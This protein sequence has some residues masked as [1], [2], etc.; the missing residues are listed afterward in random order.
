MKQD[1]P[2]S[3]YQPKMPGAT[4]LV[5]DLAIAVV[6][7]AWIPD[8]VY[9]P[10]IPMTE[11]SAW[12]DVLVPAWELK[13]DHNFSAWRH[14]RQNEG[15]HWDRSSSVP[16]VIRWVVRLEEVMPWRLGSPRQMG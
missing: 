15:Y 4:H 7:M 1:T 12:K 14:R 9:S 8:Q 16:V 3:P 13:T 5:N 6:V 10:S 2:T 11:T